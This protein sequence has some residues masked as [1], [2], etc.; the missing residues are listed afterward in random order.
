MGKSIPIA[1]F[2][3]GELSFLKLGW[4]LVGLSGGVSN[5]S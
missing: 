5:F 2:V 3:G 4:A 1:R